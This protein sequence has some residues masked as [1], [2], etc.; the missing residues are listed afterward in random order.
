MV[1][2]WRPFIFPT[3]GIT[4]LLSQL[5]VLHMSSGHGYRLLIGAFLL[6]AGSS[7]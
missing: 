1:E 7:T 4:Q 3:Q 5:H 6:I 2:N